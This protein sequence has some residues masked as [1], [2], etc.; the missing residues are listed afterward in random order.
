MLEGLNETNITVQIGSECKLHWYLYKLL[1]TH[2]TPVS[3]GYNLCMFVCLLVEE[4]ILYFISNVSL[5][6]LS[7]GTFN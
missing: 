5:S 1:N 7:E 3:G 2:E 4:S 6:L